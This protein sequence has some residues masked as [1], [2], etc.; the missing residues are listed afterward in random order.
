M[1]HFPSATDG[2]RRDA[3]IV[4]SAVLM[5]FVFNYLFYGKAPGISVPIFVLLGVTCLFVALQVSG[6]KPT[7]SEFWLVLPLLGFSAMVALRANEAMRFVNMAA[8]YG[9]FLL[10]VSVAAGRGVRR[11]VLVDFARLVVGTFDFLFESSRTIASLRSH[12]KDSAHKRV[13]G[14]VLRGLLVAVPFLLVFAVLFSSADLAFGKYASDFFRSF[15]LGTILAK[16]LIILI[17]SLFLIGAFS[18]ACSGKFLSDAEEAPKPK[19]DNALAASTFLLLINLLFLAFI[20]FQITYLFGG[21]EHIERLGFTYADYARKGFF[22]LIAVTAVSFMMLLGLEHLLARQEGR[23]S[24]A[25]KLLSSMHV[26]LVIAIV[27]S[28]HQRLVLYEQAYGFTTMRL[29]AHAFVFLL[30]AAC[31]VLLY[32]IARSER[33]QVLAFHLLL[34][35]LVFCGTLNAVNPDRF[36]AARNIE[37]YRETGKIDVG[38]IAGL[39]ADAVPVSLGL[40]VRDGNGVLWYEHVG[41]DGLRGQ[42]QVSPERFVIKAWPSFN[43][44]KARAT[45]LLRA[46]QGGERR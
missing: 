7:W 22:E 4:G 40:L 6:R 42:A 30:A 16:A 32:K 31:L 10:L 34:L 27:V 26:L 13:I 25:F 11:H 36:V 3:V 12:G 5:G 29:F 2:F 1:F 18:A 46:T 35:A 19:R 8:C 15:S 37:R 39:S 21:A 24:L 38:Y 14:Q 17:V 43:L 44:S 23:H 9:L 33:D 20:A 41:S 28:A 45:E